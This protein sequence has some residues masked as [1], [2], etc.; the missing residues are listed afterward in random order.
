MG[1]RVNTQNEN[2]CNQFQTFCDAIQLNIIQ[3]IFFFVCKSVKEKHVGCIASHSAMHRVLVPK[4]R[5][6]INTRAIIHNNR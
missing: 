6:K 2:D 4:N 1:L 5:K 3:L